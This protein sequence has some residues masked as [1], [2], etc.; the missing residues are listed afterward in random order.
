MLKVLVL[1]EEKERTSCMSEGAGGTRNS[2]NFRERMRTW[3]PWGEPG[4]QAGGKGTISSGL[5]EDTGDDLLL[6][7][8]PEAA[9]STTKLDLLE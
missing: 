5:E 2:L 6:I 3:S 9:G 7:S 8:S 4:I 1:K